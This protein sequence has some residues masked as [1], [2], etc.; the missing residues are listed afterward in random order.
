MAGS[1]ATTMVKDQMLAYA[2]HGIPVFPCIPGGKAPLTR[3]RFQD[4]Q[5]PRGRRHL[6]VGHPSGEHHHP[7]VLPSNRLGGRL[8]RFRC[9][10]LE[11]SVARLQPSLLEVVRP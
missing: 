3:T 4:D 11:S 9:C 2:G 5:R 10:D 1:P 7:T 6:V 8:R